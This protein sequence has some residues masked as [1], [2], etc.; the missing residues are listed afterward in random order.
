[1]Q[2][3]VMGRIQRNSMPEPN[4]GCVLWLART[5]VRHG[6]ETPLTRWGLAGTKTVSRA[7]WEEV[8][9]PIPKGMLVLH[10]CDNSICVNHEHLFLG[11]PKDN[12]R[13]MIK[14]GRHPFLCGAQ[15]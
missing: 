5:R 13:D 15:T 7:L 3:N 1:M 9:G 6:Y 14:K 2:R 10:R 4:S 11:T 12:T 8:H